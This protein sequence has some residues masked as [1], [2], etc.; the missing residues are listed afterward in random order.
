MHKFENLNSEL[1]SNWF[2]THALD[3]LMLAPHQYSL[4]H[5][6]YVVCINSLFLD[7]LLDSL[8]VSVKIAYSIQN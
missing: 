1:T 7:G 6:A 8:R 3:G 2:S 5:A 4:N